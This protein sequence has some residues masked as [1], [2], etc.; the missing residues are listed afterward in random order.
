MLSESVVVD[1]DSLLVEIGESIMEKLRNDFDFVNSQTL[2]DQCYHACR[3]LRDETY[4]VVPYSIIAKILNCN[5]G[6][7]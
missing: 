1:Y 3:L 6:L 5:K 4:P 2:R 7:V